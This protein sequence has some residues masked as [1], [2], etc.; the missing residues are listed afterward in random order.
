MAPR[1][2][3]RIASKLVLWLVLVSCALTI[4]G[5]LCQLYFDYSDD[6]ERVAVSIQNVTSEQLPDVSRSVATGDAATI[7][8]LLDRLVNH[9]GLAYAAVIIDEKVTWER[10]NKIAGRHVCAAF[11]LTDPEN[12]TPAILEV[13]ADTEQIWQQLTSRSIKMLISNGIK[14]SIVGGFMFF[15]FQYLVTRHLES[16]AKQSRLFDLSLPFAPLKLDRKSSHSKDELDQVVTNFNAVRKRVRSTYDSLAKNQQQL[17]LFFDST[18]EAIIGVDRKGHCSF[19]NAAC[20]SLL[21]AGENKKFIGKKLHQLF[22]HFRDQKSNKVAGEC[23]IFKS[24]REARAMHCEAGYIELSGGRMLPVSI[25]AYPVF[26]EGEVSGAIVFMID[27]SDKRQGR[28][29]REL[30]SEAV[31]QV[32]VMII[33]SDSENRIQFVNPGVEQL[34]GYTRQELLGQ[35]VLSLVDKFGSGRRKIGDIRTL[36]L[37]GKK[38]EGIVETHSKWDVPLKLFS[39]ISPVVDNNNTVVSS[40]SVSREISYELGLQSELVL[41]KKMEAV[42]RLSANFAHEF[43]NPLFGVRSFLKDISDRINFSPEDRQL[44]LLAQDECEKMRELVGGFRPSY[45]ASAVDNEQ[46]SIES[47]IRS[48]LKEVAPLLAAA[49]VT[50]SLEFI[51]AGWLVLVDKNKF[52][53]VFKNIILNAVESMAQSGGWL[54]ITT[55]FEDEYLALMVADEGVGIK[56]EHQELIFEP[57]FSTKPEI[58]GAGIGLSVAYATMK[59][60]G[61]T[62]TFSSREN[63]GSLFT[64]NI[65][66]N[67]TRQ[68]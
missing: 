44:L 46:Q 32:P 15:M 54:H 42:G 4:L 49:K 52:S 63:K 21:G 34:T 22:T 29:E 9:S 38:W 31:R 19:T 11:T 37:E 28:Q 24:M 66:T 35:S 23:L 67:L 36:L 7:L 40:I 16:L 53:L 50:Q 45:R 33:I 48:T 26:Q 3:N 59:S 41:T 68:T 60:I 5:T 20:L 14:I 51:E 62:I 43:G 10:G 6:R 1:I 25:R 47:V 58:E 18:K 57:F 13:M 27:N 30:L 2:V 55:R 56:R 12:L 17:L 65:P 64:L 8:S 61:G 39:V